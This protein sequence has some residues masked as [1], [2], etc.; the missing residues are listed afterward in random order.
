LVEAVF[1][2]VGEFSCGGYG[3]DGIGGVETFADDAFKGGFADGFVD[4]LPVF[5]SVI[6]EIHCDV[7][8]DIEFGGF[9]NVPPR[10]VEVGSV[11]IVEA[12]F[13]F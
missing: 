5:A 7:S 12:E 9:W 4:L 13:E 1:D 8:G 2:P 11:E 6:D 3:L 10:E